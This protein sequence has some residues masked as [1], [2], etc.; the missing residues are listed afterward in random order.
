MSTPSI[1]SWA[2][3]ESQTSDPDMQQTR[4]ARLYD[5]LWLIGRQWQMGEFQAEDRGTPVLARLH[6]TTAMLSRQFLGALP[7]NTQ[8]TAAAYDPLAMP[9]E[10]LIERRPMRPDGPAATPMLPL[11]VEAGQQFL[12][13]LAAEAV[14]ADYRG[15]FIRQFALQTPATP[16]ADAATARFVALH[17][18]RTPDGR[19]LATA[20]RAGIPAA[21]ADPALGI[22]AGDRAEAEAAATA[23]LPWFDGFCTEPEAGATD[24]WQPERMDYA[25]T[26]TARISPK[27]EDELS[28]SAFEIRDGRVDWSSF[29]LNAEVNLGSLPDRHFSSSVHSVVPAPVT[30]RGAP[31]PRFWEMEEARIAY[32]LMPVGPTDLGQLMAIEF[33]GSYGNDWFVVP[34]T[35]PIGALA[36]VDA[37]IVTDSF[38]VRS[39]L[40]PMGASGLPAPG[41]SMWQLD[42]IRYPG[43]APAPG[44]VHNLFFLPPTAGRLLDGPDLEEVLFA[45]DEMAN[46]AWAIERKIESPLE[47]ALPLSGNADAAAAPASAADTPLPRYRLATD[48]PENWVPLLP[49]QSQS[50]NG[51]LV[52]RLRRG[53]VLAADG[54]ATPRPAR[55]AILGAAAEL[56]I[57]DEE[58]PREGVRLTR[59]RRFARWVDGSGWLWTGMRRQVGR[60][61]GSSG[62][63][64]DRIEE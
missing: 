4:Q 64:F 15:A 6:T 55:G 14:S 2:R 39:L 40:Q 46:V 34:L 17:A 9:L 21:I 19:R 25:V 45:R 47:R 48:V 3:F 29:D 12:R 28:L 23:W 37:L 51:S 27:P 38:G 24:P 13:M 54:S 44:P 32:G 57:L 16:P 59:S 61:E 20:F 36:R 58:I 50:A 22:A 1:T 30:F 7:A 11:A 52:Q 31:A 56:S 41:W 43:E 18:G 8:T 63:R 35:L 26:L 5:P 62:L 33:A 60:G 49:V 42:L 10:A 53:A